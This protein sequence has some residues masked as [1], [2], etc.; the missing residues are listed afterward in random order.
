MLIS[1]VK[2]REIIDSRGNPT[3][4]VDVTLESGAFGRAAVPSG[5]S[6]GENE[7]LELRDGDKSRYLGKGC[8]KAVANVNDVIA[9][10][11]IGM[12]ATDQVAIDSK[13]LELDGTKTK[14]NLGANAMLG[15]SLAVAKAAAEYSE[16]PLYKYIGGTNAKT[17]PVPMMNI[18]NGG[19]HSDAT[20]AFQEFMI[21]PI[22]APTFRE[23]LRMGAEV[24]HALKKVLAA[25]NLSTAVGDEGGF[26]PMLGGTEEAIESILTAIKNAGYKPGRAE[27]GGDVSIAMDCASSEFYKDGVYDYSIFEPNGVKRTSEEQAAYL[28]ELIA[29]YPIDSIEDGMDEGDWD[30]WVKL[31]AAIGDKCQLVGDDLF[32]TNVEYLQKGIEL[33][34]ANSI[35]I[36]VNQIGTLT[37]TLDAIEMAHR[38]GY[39]SVTSHRSGETEDSTIADIAVATNSGQIKT[40]SMSRS[41]RMAKYNQLL[42]IEE[43]LGASA[44]YGYKKIYKK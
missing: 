6:T 43:E 21:R 36:K 20:I 14:S 31:N 16:L 1:D 8:L 26:A 4:E 38:A 37:E 19:S 34:A 42:R 11:I 28:A 13:L 33:G 15:V 40:G 7:A 23:G 9:K 41:D 18:I 17:L 35:L 12:D 44:I 5:A 30:G 25:K 3:V 29:K 32:V 24:F 39:T 2:A 10:E 22:G 27:E